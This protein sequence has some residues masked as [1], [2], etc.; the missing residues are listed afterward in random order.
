MCFFYDLLYNT[1]MKLILI[2]LQKALMVDDLY[3]YKNLVKNVAKL[4]KT[5]RNFKIDIVFIQ[6]DAGEGSGFSIGD[7]GYEIYD[8]FKPIEGEHVFS[9][10][11]N[12]AFGNIEFS[13]YLE[14]S[15]DKNLMIV[16]LQTEFCI[17]A[18][19]KSAYEKGFKVYVPKICHSTFDNNYSKANDVIKYYN[20]W[21]WKG[22]F[23]NV[24]TLKEAI[25]ILGK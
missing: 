4:L 11:I 10:T 2:D 18:T 23:A 20:E 22:T 3:N 17:D 9:K 1:I 14:R 15:E 16:G 21:I 6:H 12:S 19:I 5:A 25:R 8:R 24:I 7:I 13:S